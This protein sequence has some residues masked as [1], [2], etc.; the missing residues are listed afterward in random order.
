MLIDQ[1]KLD[2]R[3]FK[4]WNEDHFFKGWW[5]IQQYQMAFILQTTVYSHIKY[6]YTYKKVEERVNAINF[7]WKAEGVYFDRSCQNR[8]FSIWNTPN[9]NWLQDSV[10]GNTVEMA[11]GDMYY[12]VIKKEI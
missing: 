1:K 5:Y 9:A 6:L 3:N 11:G 8:A 4:H 12:N 2:K 10:N 7:A